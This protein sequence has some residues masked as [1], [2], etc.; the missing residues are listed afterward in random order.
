MKHHLNFSLNQLMIP[1]LS[2]FM[3]EPKGSLK[4]LI[5]KFVLSKGKISLP[6]EDLLTH[7]SSFL[8]CARFSSIPH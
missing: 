8:I 4:T 2:T 1:M 3:S 7:M 6:I 5:M